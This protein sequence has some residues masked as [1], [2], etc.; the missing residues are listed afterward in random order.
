MKTVVDG[1]NK[2]MRLAADE[3]AKY[4]KLVTGREP[5]DESDAV[6]HFKIDSSLDAAH[7]EYLV[8]SVADG[9]EFTGS[10]GRAVFYAVY[11]FSGRR[12]G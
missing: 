12:A 6:A 5:P 1:E 11:A 9:V 8:R 3:F 7:D 2:A 4:W 10:N